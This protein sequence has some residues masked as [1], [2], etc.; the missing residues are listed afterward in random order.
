MISRTAALSV[1]AIGLYIWLTPSS[2]MAQT[3]FAALGGK[4][5]DEQGGFLPGVTVIVRHLDTNTTRSGSTDGG[6]QYLFAEPSSGS[7]RAHG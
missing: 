2:T 1:A 5:T 6:G 4:V 7:I 3:S